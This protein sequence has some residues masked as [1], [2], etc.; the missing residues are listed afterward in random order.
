MVLV[1]GSYHGESERGMGA[2]GEGESGVSE[3]DSFVV[4]RGHN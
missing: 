1:L 4:T 2:K 3:R